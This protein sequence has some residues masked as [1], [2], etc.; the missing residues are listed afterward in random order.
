MRPADAECVQFALLRHG[1]LLHSSTSTSQL[2]PAAL[3]ITAHARKYCLMYEYAHTPLAKPAAH[4][5]WY[6]SCAT[7][8]FFVESVHAALFLHGLLAH[9][10]TST[11]QLPLAWL[12]PLLSITLHCAVYWLMNT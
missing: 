11:S 9:S 8:G 12:P 6:T 1:L 4:A 5:H 3:L 10:S 7:A 2:P